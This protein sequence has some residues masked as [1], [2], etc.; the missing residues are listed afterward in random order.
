M[1]KS[2]HIISLMDTNGPHISF[3]HPSKALFPVIY[4]EMI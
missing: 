1:M 2:Q 4:A 3:T